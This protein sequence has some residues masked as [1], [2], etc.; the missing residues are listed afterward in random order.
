MRVVFVQ[1]FHKI[2]R[3]GY[4]KGLTLCALSGYHNHQLLVTTRWSLRLVTN[5]IFV[6]VHFQNTARPTTATTAKSHVTTVRSEW[7]T[8]ETT[9]SLRAR[10]PRHSYQAYER[11]TE[12]TKDLARYTTPRR[13]FGTSYGTHS[14][15]ENVVAMSDHIIVRRS[16]MSHS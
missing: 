8:R 5:G 3:G 10:L 1:T 6:L 7:S 15:P 9:T 16:D 4:E 2:T 12:Q 11:Y 14:A 13:M